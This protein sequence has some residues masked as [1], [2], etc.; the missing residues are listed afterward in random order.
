MQLFSYASWGIDTQTG[1][2]PN[3]SFVRSHF[4]SPLVLACIRLVLCIYTFATIVTS[5]V[6]LSGHIAT[7]S[8]QDVNLGSYTLHQGSGAIGQSFSFFTYLTYWSLGFYFLVSSVHGFMYAFRE[9]TWLH[10]WPKW[11]QLMHS[12]FHTTMTTFPFLVTIVFWGSMNSGWPAGRFE[13][14]MNISVHGSNTVFAITEIALSATQPPPFTHLVVDKVVLSVYLGLAYLT[15]YTEG[16]YVY[17]WMNPAHGVVS[18]ILHILGYAGL[19]IAIFVVV[20]YAIVGRNMLAKRMC[21]RRNENMVEKRAILDDHSGTWSSEA[22]TIER[23]KQAQ[24]P[25]DDPGWV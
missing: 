21:K 12:L 3:Y 5:Y 13:Q 17:E 8:L 15:R 23:P 1:F 20:R 6:W 25:A 10:N 9:R 4:V 16:I 7:V 14:W 18:I 24:R 11:L 2:D 19:M 22:V